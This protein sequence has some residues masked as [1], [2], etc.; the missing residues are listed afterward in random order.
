M[1]QVYSPSGWVRS[2]DPRA[3]YTELTSR[4]EFASIAILRMIAG[5]VL[6]AGRNLYR[7]V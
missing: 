1:I 3:A 4:F 5:E 6:F 2:H 7:M